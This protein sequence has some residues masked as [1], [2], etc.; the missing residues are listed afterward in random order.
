MQIEFTKEEETLLRYGSK[1]NIGTPPLK[2]VKYLI[3]ETENAIKQADEANKKPF[4]T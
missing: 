3:F 1:Y 2:D 4:D